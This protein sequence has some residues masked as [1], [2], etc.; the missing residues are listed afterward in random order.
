MVAVANIPITTV[1]VISS[2]VSLLS[3]W[4]VATMAAVVCF[5]DGFWPGFQSKLDSQKDRNLHKAKRKHQMW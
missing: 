2:V 3:T 5:L 4:D 1:S